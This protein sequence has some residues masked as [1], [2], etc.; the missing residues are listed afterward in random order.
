MFS[1]TT[2]NEVC[3]DLHTMLEAVMIL[4]SMK[5]SR[6]NDIAKQI[7]ELLSAKAKEASSN[8]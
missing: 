8:K 6:A 3:A 7:I 4:E 1:N 2:I 5:S